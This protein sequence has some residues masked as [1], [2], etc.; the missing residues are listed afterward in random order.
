MANLRFGVIGAAQGR[1]R[2]WARDIKKWKAIG[3]TTLELA[4]ICDINGDA[5]KRAAES[6]QCNA[7]TDYREMYEKEKLDA[8]IVGT[9]HYLHAPM[10]IAAAEHGINVLTEKPMCI[11]LKQADDMKAAIE[12][13][14]IKCAVGFQHHY[15]PIYVG[16]KKVIES[17]DLGDI[18]QMN[19]IFHW[20]RKEDYFLNSSPVPENKDGDWEGWRGHWATEGASAIANQMVHF[21]D[22]FLWLSPSPLQ[23]VMAASRTAKHEFIET[24]DNT[25]A[26][27]EFKNG[28]MGLV[29]AGVAYEHDK[30]ESYAIYGTKGA[31]IRRNGMKGFLGIPKIYE[32][33]RSAALRKLKPM[34]KYMSLKAADPTK[35]MFQNFVESIVKDDA[36]IISVD[37]NSGRKSIELMRGILMSQKYGKKITIPFEDK[38]EEFPDLP[39]TFKDPRFK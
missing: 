23:S 29:Q 4:A 6:M 37:V 1:A 19:M 33:H 14:K 22:I 16:L 25:N 21:M 26:V 34:I 15:N 31:V 17:G 30:E 12:K 2:G 10:T 5:I 39:H 24:D 35:L 18:F 27:L 7:Y 36:S 38:P 20:W 8:V 3:D 28:S 11:N 13:A 9:P 32:D